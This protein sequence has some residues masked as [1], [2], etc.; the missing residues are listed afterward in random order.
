MLIP[1]ASDATPVANGLTVEAITPGPR[2][3]ED[4][5][6]RDHAVVAERER[7]RD[8]QHEE[9]QRLLP[10]PVGRAA[11]REDGHQ[12][13]DQHRAAVPEA[14]REP[15]DPGLDR[16]RLHRHGDERADGEHEEEDRR[17]AVEEA[18]L[19]GADEALALSTP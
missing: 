1:A 9:A 13:R 5:R 19:V 16:V 4:D 12:D 2:A 10:H 11:E 7:Q 6:G 18:F 3:E 15:A 8:Q 17:R 14:Q